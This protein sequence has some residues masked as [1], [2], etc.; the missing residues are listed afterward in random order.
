MATQFQLLCF[1]F[2]ACQT[3]LRL[4]GQHLAKSPVKEGRLEE[5]LMLCEPR[6]QEDLCLSC[7]APTQS[8]IFHMP[9]WKQAF[10]GNSIY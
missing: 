3:T 5:D 7:L 8:C 6:S 1:L 4:Q 2:R 9:T 10:G